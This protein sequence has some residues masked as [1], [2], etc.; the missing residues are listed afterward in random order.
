M[1]IGK[2][3]NLPAVV[4]TPWVS[5][6]PAMLAKAD[7]AKPM[8]PAQTAATLAYKM[9]RIANG[10]ACGARAA[11][12]PGPAPRAVATGRPG[13]AQLLQIGNPRTHVSVPSRQPAGTGMHKDLRSELQTVLAKRGQSEVTSEGFGARVTNGQR[14]LPAADMGTPL[15]HRAFDHRIGPAR[16]PALIAEMLE[17]H[18]QRQERLAQLGAL[19]KR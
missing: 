6:A 11:A 7:R 19:I 3:L 14:Q 2:L 5:K 17:R 8:L 16:A 4:R 10:S 9:N 12:D 15:P 1:P 13:L 18:A